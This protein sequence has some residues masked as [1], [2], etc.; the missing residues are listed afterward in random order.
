MYD[1]PYYGCKLENKAAQGRPRR[2]N[3]YEAV[4]WTAEDQD[5]HSWRSCTWAACL[6]FTFWIRR[7]QLMMMMRDGHFSSTLRGIFLSVSFLGERKTQPVRS[8]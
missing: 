3:S 2:L 6:V 5:R 1:F 8:A 4:K 7:R